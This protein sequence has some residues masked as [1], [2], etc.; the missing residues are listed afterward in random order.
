[1]DWRQIEHVETHGCDVGQQSFHVGK[2][3][4]TSWD[5]R[6]R[7]REEFVP[8]GVARS[9]AVNPKRQLL[10]VACGEGEVGIFRSKSHGL[11]ARRKSIGASFAF[12]ETGEMRSRVGEEFAIISLSAL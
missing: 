9:F 8:S 5:W 3:A 11:F 6:S 1:M 12:G 4:V 7:A 2:S 10:P